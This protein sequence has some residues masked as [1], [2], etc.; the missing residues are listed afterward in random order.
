MQM[1]SLITVIAR[2]GATSS[3]RLLQSFF[4]RNDETGF[5][6]LLTDNISVPWKVISQNGIEK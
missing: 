4:F 6:T 5:V 1:N 2:N 3:C